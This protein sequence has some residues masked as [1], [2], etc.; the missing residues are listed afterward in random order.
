MGVCDELRDNARLGD[1]LA[2]V[3]YTGDQ[4]ALLELVLWTEIIS[5]E[6]IGSLTGLTSKYHGSRG[7]PKS[8]VTSSYSRPDSLSAM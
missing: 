2:V 3:G 5:W 7:L 6:G 1:Y 8:I 4:A